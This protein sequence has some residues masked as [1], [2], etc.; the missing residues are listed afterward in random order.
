MTTKVAYK[1]PV[2]GC[3][4][5]HGANNDMF[6]SFRCPICKAELILHVREKINIV[7]M[8][9]AEVH[10]DNPEVFNILKQEYE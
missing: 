4:L 7:K 2:C 1:C 5:E 3:E 6:E 8:A 10:I 9:G